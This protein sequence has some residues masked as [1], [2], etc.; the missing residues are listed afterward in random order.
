MPPCSLSRTVSW[1]LAGREPRDVGGNQL[2]TMAE[3]FRCASSPPAELRA[4][5]RKLGPM[6]ETSNRPAWRRVQLCSAMIPSGI[7]DR[8]V[9]AAELD[10]ARRQ[11]SHAG[12]GA[13]SSSGLCSGRA[14][15]FLSD[16]Y[17]QRRYATA[18]PLSDG[19]ERFTAPESAAY[20][21][22]GGTSCPRAFQRVRH[23]AVLLPERFRGGCAFGGG[24]TS[25]A[26]SRGDR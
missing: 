6:C 1:I 12:H 8:H 14:P 24:L 19:P 10:H 17:A 22:G 25:G 7:L 13:G 4:G 11:A 21:V 23:P 26:L 3:T 9:V 15:H 5:T 18:P 16:S 20:S 2:S